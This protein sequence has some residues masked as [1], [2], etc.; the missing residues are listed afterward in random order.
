MVSFADETG[1]RTKDGTTL[2]FD[3]LRANVP[4]LLFR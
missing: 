3:K 1:T 2:P 4:P